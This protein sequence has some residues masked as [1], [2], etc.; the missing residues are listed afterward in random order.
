MLQ[1]LLPNLF[2]TCQPPHHVLSKATFRNA[3]W[4]TRELT[5]LACVEL[6]MEPDTTGVSTGSSTLMSFE[7]SLCGGHN[8]S[9]DI[10]LHNSEMGPEH[11]IGFIFN[12]SLL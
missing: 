7:Y 12:S 4:N 11:G 10:G 8:L 6:D 9:D 5:R 3:A 1:A 2:L